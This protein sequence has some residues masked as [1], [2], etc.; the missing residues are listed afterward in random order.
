MIA[1]PETGPD[2]WWIG[3]MGP[4]QGEHVIGKHWPSTFLIGLLPHSC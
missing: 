1:S 4:V 3:V 2:G